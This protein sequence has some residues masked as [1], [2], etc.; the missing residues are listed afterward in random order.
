MYPWRCYFESSD[1]LVLNTA[2]SFVSAEEALGWG[3]LILRYPDEFELEDPD[4]E[5]V[6]AIMADLGAGFTVEAEDV[7]ELELGDV[8][9]S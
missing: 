3:Q 5:V 7:K 1:G 4:G 2:D 8:P 6:P 9:A